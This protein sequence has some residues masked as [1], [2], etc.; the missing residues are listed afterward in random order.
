[1]KHLLS[2]LFVFLSISV[3]SQSK[4]YNVYVDASKPC[5]TFYVELGG[6]KYSIG[7][8]LGYTRKT[9]SEAEYLK[10]KK[11]KYKSKTY[12][13]LEGKSYFYDGTKFYEVNDVTKTCGWPITVAEFNQKRGFK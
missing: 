13:Q 7:A 3:F 1:M 4:T 5:N 6:K 12:H 10:L 8:I 11:V 2:V 9:C